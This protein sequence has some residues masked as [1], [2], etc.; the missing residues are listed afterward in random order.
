MIKS[1]F[2]LLMLFSTIFA[3]TD[4]SE[5]SNQE[6]IAIMGYV[7]QNDQ[8]SFNKELKSRIPTMSQKE[9]KEYKKN[10]KR[11]NK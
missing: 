8:R 3:K 6:L 7:K 1:V 11:L 2:I 10:K 9:K 4:F 5:M